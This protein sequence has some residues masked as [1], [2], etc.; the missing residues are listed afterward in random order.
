MKKMVKTLI[1]AGLMIAAAS[2]IFAAKKPK[3]SKKAPAQ[4]LITVGYAQVGAESD[5][6]LLT[7]LLLKRHLQKLTAIN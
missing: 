5:W 3:K 4:K 7:Q 6:R 1:I 2:S